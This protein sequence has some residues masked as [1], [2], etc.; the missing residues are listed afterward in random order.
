M[1]ASCVELER[2]IK[3]SVRAEKREVELKLEN[4]ELK[5]ENRLLKEQL[6]SIKRCTCPSEDPEEEVVQTYIFV[7]RS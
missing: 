6:D 7:S 5:E 3:R 4:E 1:Y 2:A